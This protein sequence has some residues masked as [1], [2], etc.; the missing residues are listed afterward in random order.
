MLL[1]TATSTFLSFQ[2]DTAILINLMKD[3]IGLTLRVPWDQP[4]QD[5]QINKK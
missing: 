4:I 2:S 1:E 5:S 3:K